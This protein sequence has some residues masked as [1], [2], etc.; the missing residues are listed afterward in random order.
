MAVTI[1]QVRAVLNPDEPN[2]SQASA[3]GP[4]ALPHL[5]ALVEDSDLLMAAKAAY[6]ASLIPDP[7]AVEILNRAA[8]SRQ[9]ALRVAAASAARNLPAEAGQEILALL[10]AD[11]DAGVRKTAQKSLLISGSIVVPP[12]I[13]REDTRLR[14]AYERFTEGPKGERD[15]YEDAARFAS[16]IPRERLISI[17]E[18]SGDR[19]RSVISVWYLRSEDVAASDPD[20]PKP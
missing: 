9:A 19:G 11:E 16:G 6:L 12:P 13:P 1:D 20:R 15:P 2:Y 8:L 17:S 18:S 7:R 10:G 3:L 4:A 14:V 5:A